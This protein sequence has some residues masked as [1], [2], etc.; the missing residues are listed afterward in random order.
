[1]LC[2]IVTT[3]QQVAQHL[4]VD[5]LAVLIFKKK[6]TS[7]QIL[8]QLQLYRQEYGFGCNSAA[9]LKDCDPLFMLISRVTLLFMG[10]LFNSKIGTFVVTSVKSTKIT[11][12]EVLCAKDNGYYPASAMR[13]S[14]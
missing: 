11:I 10:V 1:M 7:I 14:Y 4:K 6:F 9:I 8:W 12:V 2:L 13:L 3:Y 5:Q